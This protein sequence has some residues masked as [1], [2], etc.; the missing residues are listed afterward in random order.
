M[1]EELVGGGT[2]V[3]LGG[4]VRVGEH[5]WECG[6]LVGG[7]IWAEQDCSG[8]SAASWAAAELGYDGEGVVGGEGGVGANGEQAK[9]DLLVYLAR[10][11]RVGGGRSAVDSETAVE[12]LVGG[13]TSVALG[14]YGRVG[15]HR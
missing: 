10:R 11:E 9:A 3:A 7:L 4:D 2:P 13:G 14:G 15:E 6:M 1:A 12:A 5:R 8:G